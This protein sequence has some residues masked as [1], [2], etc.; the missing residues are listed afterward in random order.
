MNQQERRALKALR[1]RCYLVE[2][3]EFREWCN[4]RIKGEHEGP[5]QISELWLARGKGWL[6]RLVSERKGND[7]TS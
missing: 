7:R 1:E 5:L 4:L 2:E 3:T 6:A